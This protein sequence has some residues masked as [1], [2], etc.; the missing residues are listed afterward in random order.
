MFIHNLFEQ[1]V[2]NHANSIAISMGDRKL[3]YLELDQLSNKLAHQL[4]SAGV[5]P[6]DVVGICLKRSPEL[7]AGVLAILKAGAAYLPLDP[8][9]P[10]ERLKYMVAHSRVKTILNHEE[11][12][13]LFENSDARKLV[14]ESLDLNSI[15][16]ADRELYISSYY[17]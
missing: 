15:S 7:V 11:Y 5:K 17:V 8:E 6:G 9:Y 10:V 14:L 12:S 3:S 2:L 13:S 16:S 4:I 1:A